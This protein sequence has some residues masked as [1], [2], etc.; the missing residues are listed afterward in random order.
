MD[1]RT[2]K[3]RRR[4]RREFLKVTSAG[5]LTGLVEGKAALA[6]APPPDGGAG[7]ARYVLQPRKRIP[8]VRSADVIVAGAGISGLFAAL[9]AA[10][11]G[12]R[13]ILVERFGELGGN[14]GPGIFVGGHL[15]NEV[16]R[17]LHDGVF[18]AIPQAFIDR[19]EARLE[20]LPRDFVT[21]SQ[22]VARTAIEMAKEAGVET[23]PSVYPA[24]PILEGNRIR[25]LFAE[26]KGG[27]I[28]L[29]CK[30]LVDAI[31]EADLA[32]RAG[33]PFKSGSSAEECESPSVNALYRQPRYASWNDGGLYFVVAGAD[34]DK[35]L[36]FSKQEVKLNED[37]RGWA[38]THLRYAHARW[39]DA[40]V[41]VL[42]RAWESGE[43]Q[44]IRDI[45][46]NLHVA[47]LNYWFT[48]LRPGLAGSRSQV[49]GE[50]DAGNWEHVSAVESELR[51]LTYD[52]MC[53]YRKH[54][55]GFERSYLVQMSS[56]L[57]VRGGPHILGEYTLNPKETFNGLRRPDTLFVSFIE[58]QRGG[59]KRGHDMPYAMLLPRRIDGL[60]VTGRGSAYLRRGHDPS[61][62]ARG[63]MMAL[64]QATGMA[65]ALA[66]ND[67]VMPRALDIRKLQRALL[68]ENFYLGDAARLAEL[69]LEDPAQRAG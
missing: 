59:N 5:A 64:G 38:E 18:P 12:A 30:V 37:D 69:G 63:N 35:F 4:N 19:V 25:G 13:T 1:N 6:E 51:A 11:Y 68:K 2:S 14:M 44:V 53:F 49:H 60:L 43:F 42:R 66:V 48:N 8:V 10:K 9:G 36:A 29:E 40:M 16:G 55:P 41:P 34:I 24:D 32:R 39:P 26:T 54:V 17:T 22:A 31:G 20:D 57:G 3:T 61:T 27:R 15:H 65:A 62:R 33:A 58:V 52:A 28:A 56:F 47:M 46:P 7:P 67:G 21:Y 45:R 50:Y 23:L